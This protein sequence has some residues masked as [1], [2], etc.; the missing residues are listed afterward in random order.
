MIRGFTLSLSFHSSALARV[1]RVVDEQSCN[2]ICNPALTPTM[3]VIKA[4]TVEEASPS[5]PPEIAAPPETAVSRSQ[6]AGS[7]DGDADDADEPESA[8]SG[9][10]EE[11][12][13]GGANTEAQEEWDP[14]AETSMKGQRAAVVEKNTASSSKPTAPLPPGPAPAAMPAAGGVVAQGAGG[15]QAIWAPASNG[16]ATLASR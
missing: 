11:A 5:P 9:D 3:S 12:E 10:G 2:S 7:A 14:S 15:W 4:P 1:L 8:A 13:A 6:A 16:E